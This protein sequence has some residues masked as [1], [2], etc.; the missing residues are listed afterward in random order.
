MGWP[1]TCY[2]TYL[3]SPPPRRVFHIQRYQ[4][5]VH[6]GVF[7]GILGGMRR[8]VLQIL[9]LFQTK[10][11]IFHTRFQTWSLKTIEI[12]WSLLR[13]EQ[14]ENRN[15]HTSISFLIIWNW[16]D[17][18]VHTFRQFPRKQYLIP[19]QSFGPF[20]RPKR[21]KNP[22][23]WDGTHRYGLHKGVPPGLV[24]KSQNYAALEHGFPLVAFKFNTA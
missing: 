7:L 20:F 10:N 21:R 11:V 14:Q 17:K 15:S 9:I 19:D 8:P 1:T 13:L 6:P 2:L 18:Y 22:T 12:M 5:L 4:F 3:G 16:N 24:Q 23:L